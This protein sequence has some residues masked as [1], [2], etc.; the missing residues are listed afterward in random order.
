MLYP[1][2][3]EQ[4]V[5]DSTTKQNLRKGLTPFPTPSRA[6]A[7]TATHPR[8]DAAAGHRAQRSARTGPHAGQL[9]RR[10]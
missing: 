10:P 8:H 9:Q 1:P 3:R 5:Y 2:L 6:A 4:W 7:A